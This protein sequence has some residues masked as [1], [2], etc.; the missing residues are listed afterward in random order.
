MK[1]LGLLGLLL[2]MLGTVAPAAAH[3]YIVRAIPENRAVLERAPTRLQYWFSEALEVDFSVVN[4]RDQ[5]NNIVAT[6]GVSE[7]DNT[8]MTLDVP[9]DLPDG[10]YIVELRPAF[11]SDGHVVAESRVFFV[12]EEVGGVA[13][14]NATD[15]AVPLE[16]VWRFITM[17]ATML[18]FGTAIVYIFVLVP[19]WGSDKYPAGNLP[20]R[21]MRRLNVIFGYALAGAFLGNGLALIQ[22]TMVFFNTDLPGAL[23]LDLIGLV[24]V[25]SRFGDIWNWRLLFLGGVGILFLLSLAQRESQPRAIRAYWVGN[26]WLIALILGS[27]AVLS[28]A[29]GSL[30]WPWAGV[31]FHWVHTL[32]VG[33]WAAGLAALVFVLPRALAPYDGDARRAALLAALRRFSPIAFASVL[34]VVSTG[35][36]A[37][38]NYIFSLDDATTTFGGALGLKLLLVVA[39]LVVGALHHI[40]LNPTRYARFEALIQRVRGWLPTLRLESGFV[41]AVLGAAGL[42]SAT[43][44][45]IPDFA[46]TEVATPTQAIQ[47][48]ALTLVMTIS[49][50]GPGV[51]THDTILSRENQRIEDAEIILTNVQPSAGYRSERHLLE[52]VEPGLYVTAT[53]DIETSGRWWSLLD[54]TPADGEPFRIAYEWDISNE[55][56]VIQSISPNAANLAA[57]AAVLAALAWAGYPF[58]RRSVE[59]LNL[60]T[61]SVT[62][63]L[64]AIVFTVV[65]LAVG[66]LLIQQSRQQY[67][68]TI[69]PTPEYVNAVLPTQSS[70]DR[71]AGYYADYCIEWQSY[72]R[73]FND[74]RGRLDDL[75]DEDLYLATRDGWRGLPACDDTLSR[76]QRWDVVNYLRTLARPTGP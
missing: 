18:L 71:G 59:A 5:Q 43:P 51:N 48:D 75:R 7:N 12:G 34:L 32:A 74:L 38:S 20:P 69:N 70:L 15:Q 67:Q 28:H 76:F 14:A 21:V 27:H 33:F 52:P 41:F 2:L 10:A 22:Q 26:A 62:V 30:L 45:P 16:V 55:A 50:G 47:F 72:P 36:Y 29:A 40:A 61:F 64:A 6:G 56:A 3:G 23:D 54:V 35:I 46:E 25:G 11:A 9:D 13:G 4:L 65:A 58:F 39:L 73:D 49:P 53:A 1:K 24:R 44:V 37:S 68:E 66:Y 60:D 63:A 57:L 42:L 19:A 8:L 31:A 17:S